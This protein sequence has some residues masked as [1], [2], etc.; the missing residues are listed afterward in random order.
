MQ[1]WHLHPR[2]AR[3]RQLLKEK[4]KQRRRITD[5][6]AQIP[7]DLDMS[8][9]TQRTRSQTKE[10]PQIMPQPLLVKTEPATDMSSLLDQPE[11]GNNTGLY[12]VD[13]ISNDMPTNIFEVSYSFSN[14]ITK[15]KIRSQILE[16]S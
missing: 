7:V 10:Q 8:P 16:N 5:M 2:E 6:S 4:N 15:P 3:N 9:K 1:I 12:N 14:L 13:F 11:T